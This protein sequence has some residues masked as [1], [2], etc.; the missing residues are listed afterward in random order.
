MP[1]HLELPLVKQKLSDLWSQLRR[2]KVAARLHALLSLRGN[3]P[4][5]V[6][7]TQ[8]RHINNGRSQSRPDFEPN[9]GEFDFVTKRFIRRSQAV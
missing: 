5:F 8:R 6:W 1:T 7:M 3:L 9:F 4:C 2:R